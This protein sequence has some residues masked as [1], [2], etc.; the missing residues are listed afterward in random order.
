MRAGPDVDENQRPEVD[1]GEPVGIDRAVG[2]LRQVVI[3]DAEDRRGEEEGHG[4]MPIP[5]LDEA[6][7]Q[8]AE[9][10]IGVEERGGQREV[11]DDIE[12]RHGDDGGDIEP[13]G[14]VEAGLIALRQRPE[15]IHREDHPHEHHGDV[16]GPDEF[17]V[18]LSA[19]E[20]GGQRDGGSHNDELP[21]PEVDV[22]EQVRGGARLAQ[23]LGGIVNA[24][25]HHVAHEGE[26]HRV[27]VQR[28]Q[29][30]EGE[31]GNPLRLDRAHG[32]P[33]EELAVHLPP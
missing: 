28:A 12:H 17:R 3:H 18:F 6:I 29:P 22:G 11:I 24:G 2:R 31:I 10:R 26:D 19:G 5:P 25:E 16:D 7:L 23:A 32:D 21:A 15:E 8:A 1:D 27:G 14:H 33:F 9:N 13:E 20:A 4:I 30:T